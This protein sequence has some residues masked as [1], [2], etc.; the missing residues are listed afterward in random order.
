MRSVLGAVLA[1]SLL[2][3][4][5]F[6]QPLQPGRPAGVKKARLDPTY[7]VEMIGTGAAIMVAVGILASGQSSVV[8]SLQINSQPVVVPPVNTT[9]STA[10]TG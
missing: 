5:A 2:V 9:T 1:A 6:A 8:N 7:E 3:T 10:S 4:G